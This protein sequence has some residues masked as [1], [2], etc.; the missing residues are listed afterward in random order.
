LDTDNWRGFAQ[1]HRSTSASQ[2]MKKLLELVAARSVSYGEEAKIFPEFDYPLVDVKSREAM[3]ILLDD[4]KGYLNRD[5]THDYV[6][7]YL[8]EAGW[9]YINQFKTP[10]RHGQ[11]SSQPMEQSNK[12]IFV[13]H[14]HD[15]EIK[16]SVARTLLMLGLN[17]IILHEQSN[18]GKT[19]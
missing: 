2:K 7:C 1:I 5:T 14:G 19:I 4:T 3:H 15:E 12:N 10:E 6:G 11:E 9:S 17:P 13:V 16:Q 18:R 8:T